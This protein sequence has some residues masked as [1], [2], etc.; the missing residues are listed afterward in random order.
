MP[1]GDIFAQLAFPG[2]E[3]G[4]SYRLPRQKVQG[5]YNDTFSSDAGVF[6]G[7]AFV[8]ALF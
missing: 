1:V 7:S 6:D 3:D 5:S 8:V 2:T 4:V